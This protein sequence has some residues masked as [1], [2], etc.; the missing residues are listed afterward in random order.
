MSR[1]LMG[2]LFLASFGLLCFAMNF[3]AD[4]SGTSQVTTIWGFLLTLC[5]AAM[6]SVSNIVVRKAQQAS[7]PYEP[8]Q[9]LVWSSLVP[10]VPFAL[11]SLMLTRWPFP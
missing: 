8:L 5:S 7:R 1:P 4:D 3:V 10:V 6:G 9:F 2:G 11:L